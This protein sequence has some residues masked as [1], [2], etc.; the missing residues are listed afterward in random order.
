[1][2]TLI[3]INFILSVG[4]MFCWYS[5][6]EINRHANNLFKALGKRTGLFDDD[7]K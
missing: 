6:I 3:I 2:N 5:Q 1:M 4:M 7:L